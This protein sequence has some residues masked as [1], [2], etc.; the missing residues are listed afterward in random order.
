MIF[1]DDDELN[2]GLEG[3]TSSTTLCGVS[4]FF[5]PNKLD[6]HDDDKDDDEE[7][8]EKDRAFKS[9]LEMRRGRRVALV[10]S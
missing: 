10:V 8:V 4:L 1:V 2:D 5:I 3:G 9:D 7:D 6:H